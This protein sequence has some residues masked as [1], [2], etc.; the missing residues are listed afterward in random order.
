MAA[1]FGGGH[2]PHRTGTHDEH[3][4]HLTHLEHLTKTAWTRQV[5]PIAEPIGQI[6]P[7]CKANIATNDGPQCRCVRL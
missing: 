4:R 5:R 1:Q 6:L 3:A 2:Q 7:T